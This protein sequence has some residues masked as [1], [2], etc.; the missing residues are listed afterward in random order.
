MDRDPITPAHA[1]AYRKRHE[2]GLPTTVSSTLADN[3]STKPTQ[4]NICGAPADNSTAGNRTEFNTDEFLGVMREGLP[5]TA[6][7]T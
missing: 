7:V 2:E 3:S 6:Y 5:E 1:N 4:I